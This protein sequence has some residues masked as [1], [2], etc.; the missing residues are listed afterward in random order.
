M[1]RTQV[2]WFVPLLLTVGLSAQRPAGSGVAEPVDE[3][4]VEFFLAEGLQRSQ[5]MDHL[6]WICDVHGPRLTGSPNLANAQR[7]AVERFA[8][9]GFDAHTEAWGPFGRGWRCDH[10]VMEVVGDNPWPILVHAKAWSPGVDGRIEAEVVHVAAMTQEE[11]EGA[12]LRGKIVLL[13]DPREVAENFAGV[14]RRFTAEDLLALADQ[15]GSEARDPAVRAAAARR[16]ELRAGFQRRRQMLEIVQR[17]QPLAIVDRGS[18][19]EYGSIFVS[20]AS[21]APT[22]DGGRGNPRAAD[23]EVLPQ[24]TIAVEHYNRI[25]RVLAKGLAVKVAL[26]L[27]TTFFDDDLNDRNVVATLEGSDPELGEQ[28]A[29]LGAHFDSWHSGTGAT[30]NGCGSAVVLEAARLISAYCDVL[31]RKPRRSVRACL[32][33]GEEQGLLGSRAFVRE[34]FGTPDEQTAEHARVAGY[35]NL[36]NGTG[37]VRGVYLQGN[38]AAAPIFRAWLRPFHVHG[39]STLTLADTGG[40]DHL[41]FHAVGL[42]G[43]QFIQDPVS[44]DT[45]THHSNMDV[46]DHAVAEDLKQAAVVMAAFV[47]QTAERAE[48]LPRQPPPPP[49]RR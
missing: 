5:V 19:G 17:K 21:A 38:E 27:R 8:D 18:K 32:W 48:M 2:V 42:P 49:R 7:W 45:R 46:W 41:A 47:W 26:E 35:F 28:L 30:D 44:Y 6:S 29:M 43:F 31:G 4:A 3:A 12:D 22:A 34:H 23:A 14:S 20:S 40:T 15:L 36:D 33:S 25:C 9:F 10:V 11:L 24:L 16:S 1:F 39:A 37:K 13:D